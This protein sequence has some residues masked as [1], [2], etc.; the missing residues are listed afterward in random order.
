MTTASVARLG[1]GRTF[2]SPQ[3][4]TDMSVVDNVMLGRHRYLRVG[5][6]ASALNWP[7]AARKEAEQREVAYELLRF[8]GLDDKANDPIGALS[9]AQQKM[10]ELARALALEPTVLLLDEPASGMSAHE[11]VEISTL[12]RRVRDESKITPII[13][14]HDVNFIDQLCDR[15]IVLNFGEVMADGDPKSVF[16]DR[17]VIE[18]YVGNIDGEP[19]A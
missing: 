11:R 17:R 14:E 19:I 7:S 15:V 9:F 18:A 3:L 4:S 8:V 12:I 13:I 2:Q 16:A 1:V 6:L 5:L 10:V